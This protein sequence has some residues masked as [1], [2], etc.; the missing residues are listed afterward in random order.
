M[1]REEKTAE[2][3]GEFLVPTVTCSRNWEIPIQEPSWKRT[4]PE[5]LQNSGTCM[6]EATIV[7]IYLEKDG[8]MSGNPAFPISISSWNEQPVGKGYPVTSPQTSGEPKKPREW[9]KSW[10][11]DLAERS[12][13]NGQF[14]QWS[15]WWKFQWSA[16]KSVPF[17]MLINNTE[18]PWTVR[19]KGHSWH[20]V[21]WSSKG[22]LWQIVKGS[23]ETKWNGR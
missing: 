14:T 17:R 11:R 12:R 6:E 15:Y 8:M 16:L 5:G 23:C 21:V 20:R 10:H 19:D 2:K 7:M 13:R 1:L 22:R 4:W 3:V 9:R 18:G